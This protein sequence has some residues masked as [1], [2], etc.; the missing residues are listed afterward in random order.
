MTDAVDEYARHR[1]APDEWA[2][3]RFVVPLA[4]SEELSALV[5]HRGET[6][7]VSLLAGCNEAPEVATF[8]A[9]GSPLVLEAVECKAESASDGD[10]VAG[11]VQSGVDVF[12][13][14][15]PAVDFAELAPRLAAAGASGK[16]RTGGVTASAIPGSEEVLSFLRACYDAGIRFKATAG[17][18][19]AIRGEYRLT[20]DPSSPTGV[21]FGVLNI[22][23]AAALLWHGADDQVV[24]DALEET[25][26]DAFEFS[27]AG[28]SWREH[29]LSV[30][31]LNQVRSEFF[32][33]FGS[34][35]F[36]EPMA[37]LGLEA[38]PRP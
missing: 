15:S 18:H 20:Y 27:T 36:R 14:A 12:V 6:W 34:C 38:V 17:L 23:V 1:E 4:R 22:S 31:Q 21:M 16:I 35:S 28:M 5:R 26:A 2:L 9:N 24:M 19:H 10:V 29:H 25:S 33:G 37:E 3:G 32:M 7:S 8:M 11:I 30:T 13:E